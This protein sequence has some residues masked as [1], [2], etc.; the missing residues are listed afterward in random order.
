MVGE[1]LAQ[2]AERAH[3]ER[4]ARAAIGRRHDMVEQAR[5]PQRGDEAAAGGIGVVMVDQLRG[6]L[7][8]PGVGRR[9]Q[10]AVPLVEEGPGEEAAVGHRQSPMKTG[11]RF[12]AKAS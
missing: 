2:E 1:R 10:R 4:R 5:L 12:S 6:V 3:V 11:L 7:G 8:A 9:L